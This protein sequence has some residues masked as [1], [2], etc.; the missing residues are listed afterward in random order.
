MHSS[1]LF[2][3]VINTYQVNLIILFFNGFYIAADYTQAEH[4]HTLNY[5]KYS[6][7]WR[8]L[9]EIVR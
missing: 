8:E 3:I 2:D 9:Q 7:Q 4:T 6:T 5:L 1:L